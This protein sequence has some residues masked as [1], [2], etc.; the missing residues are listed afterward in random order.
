MGTAVFYNCS[1][2]PY[3]IF[4]EAPTKGDNPALWYVLDILSVVIYF[5]DILVR[6]NT[7]IKT[8]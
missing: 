2:V 1:I 3:G 7:A 6:M 8:R 4:F 5:L